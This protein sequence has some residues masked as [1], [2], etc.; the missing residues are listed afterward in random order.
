MKKLSNRKKTVNP[1]EILDI[2]PSADKKEILRQ[3]TVAMKKRQYSAKTIV[4]SQKLLFN[5]LKRAVEEFQYFITTTDITKYKTS[6]EITKQ[7]EAN[8][9]GYPIPRLL[10]FDN[11]KTTT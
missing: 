2:K 1:F 5:P 4:E 8:N 11:E 7:K 9:P 6:K 10:N 3:V